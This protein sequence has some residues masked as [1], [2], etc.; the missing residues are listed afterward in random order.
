MHQNRVNLCGNCCG[1]DLYCSPP[2]KKTRL[3][4]AP[5]CEFSVIELRQRTALFSAMKTGNVIRAV[6]FP[7]LTFSAVKVRQ[8]MAMCNFGALSG[9]PISR[10]L[11]LQ[12]A[13]KRF[14]PKKHGPGL[15]QY[16]ELTVY[17]EVHLCVALSRSSRSEL[18]NR[19]NATASRQHPSRLW[20]SETVAAN[21]VAAIHPPIDD[22]DPIWKF[23]FDPGRHTDLQNP[24]EFSP[25]VKLIQNF[26]IDPTSSIRTRL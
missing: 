3:F 23:S 21:R 6:E 24:A 25:K 10:T 15:Q 19:L 9:T 14:S 13:K 4:E 12:R 17:R 16:W 11:A 22:T 5:R 7:C 20:D 18:R 1:S 2:Q 26:S 8:R